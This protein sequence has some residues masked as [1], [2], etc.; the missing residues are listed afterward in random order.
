VVKGDDPLRTA[1]AKTV[2]LPL[3][4]A[5][6]LLLKEKITLRGIQIPTHKEIYIPVLQDLQREGIE[7]T[8]THSRIEP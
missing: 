6:L 4:M 5:A 1:M 3:A 8:E 2:G 7:F